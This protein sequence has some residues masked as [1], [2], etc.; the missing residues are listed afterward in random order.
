[1][2]LTSYFAH[3]KGEHGVSIAVSTPKWWHGKI[4]KPLLPPWSL[5]QLIKDCQTEETIELYKSEY[6]KQ[7]NKLDLDKVFKALDGRVLLCYEPVGEFCHRHIV[8]EWLRQNGYDIE[9]MI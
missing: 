5:V 4:Y 3:Y 1:M 8:S 7:L 2:I 9:E 6:K